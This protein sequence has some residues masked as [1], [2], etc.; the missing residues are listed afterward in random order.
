MISL[1]SNTGEIRKVAYTPLIH[2]SRSHSR[3]GSHISQE[4]NNRAMQKE[5]EHLKKELRHAQRRWTPS[6]FDSSSNSEKDDS[7]RLRSRTPP[8]KSFSYEKEY[9]HKRRYKS[10]MRKG[11]GNDAMSKCWTRFPSQPSR[12]R[13]KRQYFLGD[14]I[15]QHSPSTMVKRT[16]WS[17]WATSIREWFSIL[18]T[19][20]WCARYSHL[21]WDPWRWDGS[22]T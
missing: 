14:S 10:L 5:I 7:Y 16:L 13:S 20:P 11:L 3:V 1:T 15:S 4:Q 6:Q 18:R 9:H 21:V 22:T 19:K 8:S 2:T 17:M 12:A